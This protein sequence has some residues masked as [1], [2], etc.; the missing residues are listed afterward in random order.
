M[1]LDDDGV[2]VGRF[3][4]LDEFCGLRTV[5]AGDLDCAHRRNLT[6]WLPGTAGG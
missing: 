3:V 1:H 6:A 2:L 4:Q 5:E